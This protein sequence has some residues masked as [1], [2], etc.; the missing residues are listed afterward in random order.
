MILRAKKYKGMVYV[1]WDQKVPDN[2]DNNIKVALCTMGKNEK[3][4]C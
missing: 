1:D 2:G 3:S 4:L